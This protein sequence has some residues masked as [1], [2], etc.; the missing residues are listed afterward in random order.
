V[1][2]VLELSVFVDL[3]GDW[4]VT[5]PFA[6]QLGAGAIDGYGLASN[7][8]VEIAAPLTDGAN[9]RKILGAGQVVSVTDASETVQVTLGNS[10][11]DFL[12][13]YF[14]STLTSSIHDIATSQLSR[15]V[16]EA[17]PLIPPVSLDQ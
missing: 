7:V 5:T 17:V 12:L 14:S 1:R 15:V 13:S 11:A 2:I 8:R 16:N 3:G 9:G 4:R 10:A 6:G